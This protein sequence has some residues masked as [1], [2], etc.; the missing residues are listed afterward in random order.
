[1]AWPQVGPKVE[2]T[3]VLSLIPE[4]GARVSGKA[5]VVASYS[6]WCAFMALGVDDQRRALT[7][8]APHTYQWDASLASP[9]PHRRWA[10]ARDAGGAALT[11]REV[12]V[13]VVQAQPVPEQD[14]E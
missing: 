7:N 5:T 2:A 9:G 10:E 1:M 8:V 4:Q 11:R 13:T 3:P 14:E 6:G 12:T